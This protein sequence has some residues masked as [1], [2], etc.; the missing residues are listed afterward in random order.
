M[1]RMTNNVAV[2]A[3]GTSGA[4]VTVNTNQYFSHKH[5]RLVIMAADN[6]SDWKMAAVAALI[7]A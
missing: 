1:N 5:G 4:A 7:S 3:A 6:Y 2:G